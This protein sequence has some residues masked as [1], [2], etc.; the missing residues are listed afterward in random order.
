MEE[1]FAQWFGGMPKELVTVLIAMIPIAELRGAIPW[2]LASPP[3]GGGLSWQAA[4][5]YAVLG[6]FIPIIPL[7]LLIEP[8]TKWLRKF[9]IFDK[10]F[11]WLFTRTR[12]KIQKDIE[13]Y[14]ALGL[15]IFVAIPLP[16][17]GAWT[18]ALAAFIFGIRFD[19][20]VLSILA[21]ICIAGVVV[22]LASMGVISVFKIFL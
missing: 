5:F 6:N 19:R 2:A 20:A 22:T 13:R 9:K 11:E 10:F 16:A 17:T 8:V 14:E 15:A 18:G 7:L 12:R 3:L 21:G 1:Q 4:F